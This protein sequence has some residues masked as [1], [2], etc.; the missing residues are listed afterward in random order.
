M[1]LVRVPAYL[2]QLLA[3]PS[4][5]Q[6]HVREVQRDIRRYPLQFDPNEQCTTR[7]LQRAGDAVDPDHRDHRQE[8]RQA[9]QQDRQVGRVTSPKDPCA[10]ITIRRCERIYPRPRKEPHPRIAVLLQRHILVNRRVRKEFDLPAAPVEHRP[11]DNR[12]FSSER[13]MKTQGRHL[14]LRHI[15]LLRGR[16]PDNNVSRTAPGLD[17][18]GLACRTGAACPCVRNRRVLRRL[19]EPDTIRVKDR[20]R[21]RK[22]EVREVL[23]FTTSDAVIT[24][25]R[26]QDPRTALFIHRHCALLAHDCLGC[27]FLNPLPGTQDSTDARGDNLGCLHFCDKVSPKKIKGRLAP[28]C[29]AANGMARRS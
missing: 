18:V 24:G 7:P 4:L 14:F 10:A 21:E 19:R 22:P 25:Q 2:G 28:S 9:E 26:P 27:R 3:R 8:Q 1:D 5:G 16:R 17:R 11:G 13:P 6:R 15:R 20:L 29:T 23:Y 12:R